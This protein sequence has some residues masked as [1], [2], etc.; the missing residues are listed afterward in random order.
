MHFIFI[1]IC[2]FT[3]E[4]QNIF[5][6]DTKH[7]VR[8]HHPTSTAMSSFSFMFHLSFYLFYIH[9]IIFDQFDANKVNSKSAISTSMW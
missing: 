6:T 2:I 3:L 9:I 1:Y 5:S 7:T 4:F 8:P